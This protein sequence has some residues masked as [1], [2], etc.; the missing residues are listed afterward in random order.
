MIELRNI[1]KTFHAD[2]LSHRA[3][4]NISAVFPT[5]TSVALLGRNG[6][7]KSSLLKL[8]SGVMKPDHG[9]VIT[10]GT[11]SWPVGYAGSFHRELTG[12]QNVRFIARVYGVDSDELIDFVADF[13]ELGEYFHMPVR[14]YS[15]GMRGKL[16][17]GVSM[18]IAF[19]TYLFDEATATGDATFRAKSQ[20][21]VHARL[22]NASAVV[23]GH[24]LK[25]LRK[26]CDRGA[27][28]DAGR[29]WYYDD[30]E[31]AFDHYYELVGSSRE[32][33]DWQ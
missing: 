32:E 1:T 20:R 12:A 14:T 25:M 27:V 9:E 21:Y 23:V 18:G 16:G 33:D 3:A 26:L 19:D 24:G 28:I 4:D 2:G 15:A 5:G 8:I 29:L 11:I 30:I 22:A 31:D 10:D 13:A 7:G 6:A 17:F